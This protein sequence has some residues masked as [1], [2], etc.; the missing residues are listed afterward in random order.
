ML[1]PVAE[2]KNPYLGNTPRPWLR[3][4]LL[5]TYGQ[6]V[7]VSLVA[8]TGNPYSIVIAEDLFDRLVGIPGRNIVSNFGP[9][10][11]GW[12]R[13]A[14]PELGLDRLVLG[15]GNQLVATAVGSNHATFQG[16]V[17]LPILRL[18][19]YG[20]NSDNFWFR[21]PSTTSSS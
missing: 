9:M 2:Q 8:D 11:G 3:L 5:D 13:I 19:E 20:G 17:G 1:I 10:R 12:L 7:E 15:Y 21:S 18:G 16:L 14:M 6:A 4:R